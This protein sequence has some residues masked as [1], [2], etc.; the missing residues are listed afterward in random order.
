MTSRR[1]DERAGEWRV[2]L[3]LGLAV[4]IA[5]AGSLTSPFLFDDLHLIVHNAYIKSLRQVWSCVAAPSVTSVAGAGSMF[6]PLVL[7][8]YALNY[9]V[10][11]LNPV[12]YHAVNL[13]LHWLNVLLVY[14]LLTR[15]AGSARGVALLAS[16]LFAVHPLNSQAVVHLAARSSLLATT[17]VLLGGLAF[18]WR[19][20]PVWRS[21]LL[22]VVAYAAGLLTKEMAVTLPVLVMWLDWMRT[23]RPDWRGWWRRLW[24]CAALLVAYLA[25]RHHLYGTLTTATPVRPWGINLGVSCRAIFLYM[26][27][28]LAPI[29][30]CL[31]RV[32]PV[33]GAF[34]DVRWWLPV[35]GYAAL[36]VVTILAACRARTRGL[37]L[38]LGWFLIA[39]LPSHPVATFNLPA[40]EHHSY[41]PNIGWSLLLGTVAPS[42]RVAWWYPRALT[43]AT[44]VLCVVWAAMTMAR[45]DV[46][47]DGVRFWTAASACAP[48]TAGVWVSLAQEY[49]ARHD[50][51]A[52]WRLYQRALAL[53]RTPV[54][55]AQVR[56]NLGRLEWQAHR[57]DAAQRDLARALALDPRNAEAWNNLGLVHE[58]AGRPDAARQAYALALALAPGLPDPSQNLGVLALRQGRWAEAAAHFRAALTADPDRASAHVGLDKALQ[59]LA[60]D[61]Q[62]AP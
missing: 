20:G 30:L 4:A 24:P 51:R 42:R 8:S 31:A 37:A 59:G 50:D 60:Q 11:G 53:S 40:A 14:L 13:W 5:Y 12:G 29:D 27:L 45:V 6:R 1:V 33:P 49:E 62:A 16:L 23:G 15:V 25:W 21:T 55:E 2:L 43:I 56:V 18:G 58:D 47:R 28:W 44:S 26:R 32:L 22:T 35:S 36:W 19:D 9:A 41:L 61:A 38:G 48:Q 54:E 34:T 52:A 57:L 39:L 17:W 46:W 10:G 7:W 3:W